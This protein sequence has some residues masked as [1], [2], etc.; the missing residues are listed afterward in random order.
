MKSN[1]QLKKSFIRLIT[2]CFAITLLSG[3]TF[4]ET[5]HGEEEEHGEEGH[6]ELTQ[7]QIKHA[8]LRWQPLPRAPSAMFCQYMASSPPTQSVYSR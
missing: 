7:E 8:A 5:G 1:T 4:A 3:Q 2:C 6:V